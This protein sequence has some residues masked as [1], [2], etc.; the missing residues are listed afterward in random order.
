[1][2]INISPLRLDIF[3]ASKDCLSKCYDRKKIKI[4]S[5]KQKF[6]GDIDDNESITY[7]I[8]PP[9]P[10]LI[11]NIDS[12]LIHEAYHDASV[13]STNDEGSINN[14]NSDVL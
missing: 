14:L 4:L 10:P 12:G 7:V 1:L 2:E 9:K 11:T 5:W 8:P 13:S 3:F 6:D